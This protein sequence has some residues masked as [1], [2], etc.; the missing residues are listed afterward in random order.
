M[1]TK[2]RA[3]VKSVTNKVTAS[4][5]TKHTAAMDALVADNTAMDLS[6]D[7]VATTPALAPVSTVDE[8]VQIA[9]IA[10]TAAAA[11][12]AP[13]KKKAPRKRAAKAQ[14]SATSDVGVAL[15]V[16]KIKKSSAAETASATETA[17][18]TNS[19]QT[20]PPPD[21]DCST[22]ASATRAAEAAGAN[23]I[24][25]EQFGST[26]NLAPNVV[27]CMRT[28]QASQWR[29]LADALKDLVPECAVKFDNTGLKI[30]SMDLG[31]VALVHLHATSEFY[32]C[33]EE[34]TLGLNVLALYRMLR[35]LTTA[36]YMLE[37]TLLSDSM[38]YL[39]IIITN[40]DKKTVTK[41]SLRLLKLPDE[42]IFIPTTVFHRVLSMPSTDF[43]R[44]VR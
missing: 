19:I 4:R 11:A 35:N 7:N 38:D 6:D 8:A 15:K 30:I 18:A 3:C 28:L 27:M 26:E 39:Q 23:S 31:H 36:G 34:V 20:R 41:N 43:Q 33:K 1:Y 25:S 40:T 16:K 29:T 22:T 14:T 5:Q 42:S 32:Y 37:F 12:A 2:D 24:N 10:T 44:Y 13:E 21:A 17:Q 9:P